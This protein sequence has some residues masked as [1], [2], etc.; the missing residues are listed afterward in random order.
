M[1]HSTCPQAIAGWITILCRE[2]PSGRIGPLV[3]NRPSATRPKRYFPTLGASVTLRASIAVLKRLAPTLVLVSLAVTTPAA[4]QN[5]AS[6]LLSQP[7]ETYLEQLRVQTGIPGMSGAVVLDGRIIWERGFGFQNVETR[8][9]ATPDTPYPV[10]DLTQTLAAVL[11]LQ[12]TELRL[13][14]L[15]EPVRRYGLMFPEAGATLRQVMSHTSSGAPGQPFRYAPERYAQ[16]TT[17]IEACAPQPYRKSVSH[18]LLERLAMIDSVPGRDLQDPTVAPESLYEPAALQRYVRVLERMAMPYRVN[19]GRSVRAELPPI[20]GINAAT[21]LVSTVRDLARFDAALDSGILLREE[22]LATAWTNTSSSDLT[23]VPMGLG[24]FVQNYR[25]ERIVW[26]FGL[27][28]NGYSSLIVKV[29]SRRLTFVLLANSE[30]LA[31]PFQLASGDVTRS[32]FA[33]VFLRLFLL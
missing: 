33:T 6:P 28:S 24:W 8:L 20:E 21:G 3:P 15:D 26:H 16:L 18:R 17:L 11:L 1:R 10:A 31:A 5:P 14:D 19:R 2:I 32:L 23:P 29:P 22:T 12:C 13:L 7:L 25:G 27:V 30:G 4:G 9:R